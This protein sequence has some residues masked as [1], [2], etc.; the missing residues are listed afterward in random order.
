MLDPQFAVDLVFTGPAQSAF[1]GFSRAGGELVFLGD[2]P[3]A[4]VWSLLRGAAAY[5]HPSLREGF[6]LPALEALRVG[7]LAIVTSTSTP[8]PLRPYVQQFAPG[9]VAALCGLLARTLT[10]PI[11]ARQEA[12]R[13]RVATAAL[14][15]DA[16]VLRTADVYREFVT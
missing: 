12:E 4:D 15:W 1:D 13:G 6:G 16:M 7:T 10:D 5:V 11:S 2:V 14:T 8:A 9:D 3:A